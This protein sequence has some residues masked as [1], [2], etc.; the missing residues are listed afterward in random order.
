VLRL[1]LSGALA[2]QRKF[3]QAMEQLQ[4]IIEMQP[5]LPRGLRGGYETRWFNQGMAAYKRGDTKTAAED[6]RMALKEKPEDAVSK[7]ALQIVSHQIQETG[8]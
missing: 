6:F 1:N 3:D 4:A 5:S 8:K 2:N 7:R